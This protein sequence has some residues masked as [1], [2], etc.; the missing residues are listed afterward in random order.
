MVAKRF[1]YAIADCN[2]ENTTVRPGAALTVD[3]NGHL[4]STNENLW[5]ASANENQICSQYSQNGDGAR[6]RVPNQKELT[7]MRRLGV[8]TQNDV[9]WLSCTQEYYGNRFFGVTK[10]IS[11]VGSGNVGN[12]AVRCVRDVIGQ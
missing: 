8:F 4:S 9:K 5:L 2:S 12:R 1:E 6:W 11:T 10:N 7:I 3:A